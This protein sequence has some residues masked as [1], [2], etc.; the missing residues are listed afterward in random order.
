MNKEKK[1][2]QDL[3]GIICNVSKDK[4]LL[5]DFLIDLLTPTEYDDIM[6]RWQIVKQLIRNVLQREIRDRLKASIAT[7]TR[8]SRE[9]QYGDGT[10]QKFYKR[11]QGQ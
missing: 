3:L 8:G 7:V 9:L 2:A 11:L 4:K 1:Y 5:N 6:V 10:F